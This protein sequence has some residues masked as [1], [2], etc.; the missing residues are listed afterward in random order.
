MQTLYRIADVMA[1]A[2]IGRKGAG[3]NM[4]NDAVRSAPSAVKL[5]ACRRYTPSADEAAGRGMRD[6]L[7][8]H[9]HLVGIDNFAALTLTFLVSHHDEAF[10]L[11]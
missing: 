1:S 11:A 3:K 10:A 7:G 9:L 2:K 4:S 5:A 6:S 8:A